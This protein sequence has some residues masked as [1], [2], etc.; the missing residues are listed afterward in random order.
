MLNTYAQD[1]DDFVADVRLVAGAEAARN[2]QRECGGQRI[3]IPSE[4]RL[5]EGSWLVEAIGMEA[6]RI[7]CRELAAAAKGFDVTIPTNLYQRRFE[8]F[9]RLRKSGVSVRRAARELRVHERT[10]WNLQRRA[11]EQGL[12]E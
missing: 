7:V 12:L 4:S 6:A 1:N 3:P 11:R 10:G 8:D 2:L 5:T 9:V